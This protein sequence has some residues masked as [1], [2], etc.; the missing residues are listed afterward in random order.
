MH[1]TLNPRILGLLTANILYF[2]TLNLVYH[3][4]ILSV[5]VSIGNAN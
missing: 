2:L 5:L 3:I 1:R 4:H